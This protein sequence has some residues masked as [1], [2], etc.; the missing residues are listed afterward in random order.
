MYE[1]V[2]AQDIFLSVAQIKNAL[3]DVRVCRRHHNYLFTEIL[4]SCEQSVQLFIAFNED[5]SYRVFEIAQQL[6]FVP[7]NRRVE[8]HLLLCG[9]TMILYGSFAA[10]FFYDCAGARCRKVCTV[11]NY[12]YAYAVYPAAHFFLIEIF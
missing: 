1:A 12:I 9:Y 4:Y 5:I 3:Y 8:V 6:V 7:V 10:Y 11:Y 2:Y